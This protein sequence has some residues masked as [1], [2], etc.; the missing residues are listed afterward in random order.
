[1]RF[2]RNISRLLLSITLIISG[3][4]K[5]IEPVGTSLK[6]IEYFGAFH[7]SFLDPTAI[8]FG[9]ALATLEFTLGVCLIMHVKTKLVSTITLGLISFFTIV[10][11]YLTIFNPIDDC[12]CFGEAIHLTNFQTFIKNLVLLLFSIITF[13]QGE[14]FERITSNT[15]EWVFLSF[16]VCVAISISILSYRQSAHIDFTEYQRGADLNQDLS[17]EPYISSFVYE[18]DGVKQ[19]FD[20]ENLPDDKWNYVET[21]TEE[22]PNY[23]KAPEFVVLDPDGNEYTQSILKMENAVIVSIYKPE[24]IKNWDL[25]NEFGKQIVAMGGDYM[26]L[27]SDIPEN[28]SEY[29][30]Y[31]A[32]FC[33]Y[34]T[35]ISLNRS[36]GGV[37][38]IKNG[39]ICEKVSYYELPLSEEMIDT[40]L[41]E[42]EDSLVIKSR[43][44][45][46]LFT[47]GFI[48]IFI[49]VLFI[50]KN[51]CSLTFKENK[52]T[53]HEASSQ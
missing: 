47:I 34:K 11:L 38:F 28:I 22:N 37:S 53:S 5:L 49:I 8:I 50:M 52:K 24:K 32:F 51:I 35:L 12:G 40:F 29:C 23:I 14:K 4:L 18:L 1:M 6:I 43:I 17:E 26:V 31:P 13:L 9:V 10:T 3:F 15:M 16:Y 44:R 41:T 2:I 21:I 27:F 20:I 7:L 48:V 36:N 30:H 45:T 46:R 33:D 39:I 42:D 19:T 25:I